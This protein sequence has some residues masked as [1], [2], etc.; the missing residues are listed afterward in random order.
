MP[1]KSSQS[2]KKGPSKF[3]ILREKANKAVADAVLNYEYDDCTFG[4]VVKHLGNSRI[5]VMGTDK[6]EYHAVIRCLLRKKSSTPIYAGDIVIISSRDFESRAGTVDA[7]FDVMSVLGKKD[8]ASL[9]KDKRIP[10][11]MLHGGTD[12]LS[13]DGEDDL[14]DYGATIADEDVDIDAI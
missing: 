8:I 6:K 9:I 1:S 12:V 10:R 14:F 11:W 2:S 5:L 13:D 7:R 3:A 4:K